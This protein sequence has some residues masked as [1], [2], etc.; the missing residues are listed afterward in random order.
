M[1]NLRKYE[2]PFTAGRNDNKSNVAHSGNSDVDVI[3]EVNTMPIAYAML[4]SLLATNQLSKDE[5]DKA[6]K[7]LKSLVDEDR[8]YDRNDPKTAKIY[9]LEQ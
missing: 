5:F 7:K 6:V 1:S 8:H 2:N 9:H 3:V 4:C